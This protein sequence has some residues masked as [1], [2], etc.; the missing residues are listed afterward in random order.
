MKNKLRLKTC[1]SI[2]ILGFM[3]SSNSAYAKPVIKKYDL[4]FT[5]D[6][7]EQKLHCKANLLLSNLDRSDTLSLLLYRLLR[8]K[9]VKD[10]Q[11]NN[12]PFQQSVQSFSDWE[13]LQVNA[14]NIF[15]KRNR[16]EK[17][18]KIVI[19]YEGYLFGYTETGMNYVKDNINSNFTIL[20]MDSYA[21]PVQGIPSWEKNRAAGLFY[22]DYTV[23][24][25]VPDSLTVI[26][27][28]KLISKKQNENLW[29][30]VYENLK[31]AWR[32]DI[33][34]SQ[35]STKKIDNFFIHYFHEDSIG[36]NRVAYFLI[37]AKKMLNNWF[38]FIAVDGF[39]II[40][41]PDGW[42]SQT[43]V[44]CIL[45]E[46]SVF[47]DEKNLYELYHEISHIWNVTSKDKYPCRL[48][49]EGLAVFLQYLLMEK[50]NNEMGLLDSSAQ[51]IFVR[52]K[53]I[54]KN[55]SISST[56]PIIDYGS[57]GLTDL[58]YS[59]GMLFYYLL[60]KQIGENAF[61]TVIKGY[62]DTFRSSGATT[63]EFVNYLTIKLPDAK[64]K[65][66]VSDWILTNTSSTDIM[67][68]TSIQHLI[69]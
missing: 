24:V 60:Y 29:T 50:L 57:K 5:F 13:V 31:P 26:N 63:N 23:S 33:A 17:E 52:L 20:R 10:E 36:A 28:G 53:E 58:S 56:T 7:K 46:S 30:Y 64:I 66:L 54:F 43:D 3:F 6:F 19:E 18:S 1:L 4:N 8:V 37:E 65:A 51:K 2:L 61:M 47:R 42:G 59:K 32:I 39:S 34:I 62:Y 27:G 68:E 40:E 41:I 15:L 69:R 45:Q 16:D 67:T 11:G 35:Y 38:G 9:S 48:E 25:T 55:D 12:I 49:S 22:F 44:T 21:Y 14:I